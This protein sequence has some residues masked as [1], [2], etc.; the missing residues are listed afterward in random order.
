[1][2]AKG[3]VMSIAS[4]QSQGYTLLWLVAGAR[5]QLFSAKQGGRKVTQPFKVAPTFTL[6]AAAMP[7]F[8][9]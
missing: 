7:L 6:M 9:I 4:C 8:V 3:R 1:M 5:R 2:H